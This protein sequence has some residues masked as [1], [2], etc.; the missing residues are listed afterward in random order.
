M[1]PF[2]LD[3]NFFI[4]AHRAHYPFDVMPGFWMKVRDLARQQEII[5]TDKVRTEIFKNDD[6]LTA[7]CQTHLPPNFFK[8]SSVALQEYTALVTWVNTKRQHFKP[9]AINA[10]LKTDAADA[11]IIAYAMKE[12]CPVLTHEKSEPKRKS[13]VKIPDVC[14]DHGVDYYT[15]IEMFRKLMVRI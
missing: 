2:I 8:D 9:S 15:T 14:R 5:S 6:Q 10:F 12:K 1:S 4:Q 13:R 3:S 7:W 11:W